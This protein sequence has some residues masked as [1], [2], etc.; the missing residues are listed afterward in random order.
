M[1]DYEKI[2]KRFNEI[3]KQMKDEKDAGKQL[4]LSAELARLCGVNDSKILHNREEIDRFFMGVP[5]AIPVEK[6][7]ELDD[8]PGGIVTTQSHRG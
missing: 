1:I 3:M 6:A 4:E 8:E 7:V 5:K 2:D